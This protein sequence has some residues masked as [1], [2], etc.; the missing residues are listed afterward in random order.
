[1]VSKSI[2]VKI[3]K[4]SNVSSGFANSAVD[5]IHFHL[6]PVVNFNIDA[7]VYGNCNTLGQTWGEVQNEFEDY[8]GS[9]LIEYEKNTCHLLI[10]DRFLPMGAG[11]AWVDVNGGISGYKSGQCVANA[12]TKFYINSS[13]YG[14]GGKGYENT[15]IHEVGHTLGAQHSMVQSDL[16]VH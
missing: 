12:A 13:C 11:Y 14:D 10:V 2:L 5:A 7:E 4:D 15:V 16:S 3:H 8:L 9:E 6:D 1:M